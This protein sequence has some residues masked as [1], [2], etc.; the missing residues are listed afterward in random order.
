MNSPLEYESQNSLFVHTLTPSTPSPII[1][2]VPHDGLRKEDFE[3][4]Y[5]PRKIGHHIRD[6]ST[7][8]VAKDILLHHPCS[9]VRGLMPRMFVDYNRSWPEAVNYCPLTKSEVHTAID[10]PRLEGPYKH[11]HA[12]ISQC[13]ADGINVFGKEQVLLLDIHGFSVQ[14]PH[15]PPGGYDLIFG[16][17]NRQTVPHHDIDIALCNALTKR[18]YKIFLPGDTTIGPI[19]D[20]Y[21]ADYTTRHHSARNKI[22]VIQIEI[23]RHLRL[24]E[25]GNARIKL[26]ID[27][28]DC[29]K[30]I[31][32]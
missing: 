29:L 32:D 20:E 7:W 9:A 10:D 18:G 4:I 24:K 16:T 2:S 3:G 27:L 5:V 15:A 1:L 14:P 17:G 13:I 8:L 30:E 11:Y 22:N 26:S 6:V 28:A 12:Q 19:E 21:S 23:A 31:Y 25:F